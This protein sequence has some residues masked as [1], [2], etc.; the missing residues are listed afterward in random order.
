MGEA[1]RFVS[2]RVGRHPRKVRTG[3]HVEV[4]VCA[5]GSHMRHGLGEPYSLCL[6]GGRFT[7]VA[8]CP[9]I[10]QSFEI[11]VALSPKLPKS[12]AVGAANAVVKWVKTQE[13]RLF[14][15]DAPVF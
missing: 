2:R 4:A 1:I 6:L 8:G 12:A 13:G 10:T 3:M 15:K 5:Y 9:Q 14:L 11:Y 7:N